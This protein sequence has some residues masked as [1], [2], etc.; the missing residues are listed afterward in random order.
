M[1]EK[2]KTLFTSKKLWVIISAIIL[3]IFTIFNYIDEKDTFRI[4]YKNE[5]TIYKIEEM[6]WSYL[7]EYTA[8]DKNG[9][10][11][12]V[13]ESYSISIDY[14]LLKKI[15]VWNFTSITYVKR[16]GTKIAYDSDEYYLDAT[17][18]YSGELFMGDLLVREED[19]SISAIHYK[20]K[21][22][23]LLTL[24][25]VSKTTI[26]NVVEI[27]IGSPTYR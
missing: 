10:E 4:T 23:E 2:L 26:P 12:T 5:T 22:D 13:E 9:N 19:N 7:E 25:E 3:C 17:S 14:D 1:S 11:Y 18:G 15:P 8:I 16:D 6:P 21:R 24:E 27:I 20:Y